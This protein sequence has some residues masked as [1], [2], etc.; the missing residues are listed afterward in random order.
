MA[1]AIPKFYEAKKEKKSNVVVP[2]ILN[3]I[4]K[5]QYFNYDETIFK[6]TSQ[7]SRLSVYNFQ[8]LAQP[9]FK[10]ESLASSFEDKFSK[11]EPE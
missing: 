3:P 10:T 5:S 7:V 1:G 8:E 2:V 6:K 9:I 11:N 4:F